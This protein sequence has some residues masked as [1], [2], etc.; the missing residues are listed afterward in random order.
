MV[1][2]MIASGAHLCGAGPVRPRSLR[3]TRAAASRAVSYCH[4]GHP[5]TRAGASGSPGSGT[6]TRQYAWRDFIFSAVMGS[7]VRWSIT[8]DP[9]RGQVISIWGPPSSATPQT[10]TV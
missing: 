2:R 8:T 1:R 5:Q 9:H 6:S 10:L 4:S 7:P 3:L